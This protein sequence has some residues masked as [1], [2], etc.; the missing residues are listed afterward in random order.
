MGEDPSVSRPA[1]ALL[2]IPNELRAAWTV[3]LATRA[4]CVHVRLTDDERPFFD[5]FLAS[6]MDGATRILRI[7]APFEAAESYGF[8]VGNVIIPELAR[9]QFGRVP[10]FRCPA[11]AR[12]HTDIETLTA[13]VSSFA[14]AYS[15]TW[16]KTVA[17]A[18]EPVSVN[19]ERAW[20]RWLET[21]AATI[22]RAAPSVRLVLTD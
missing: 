4:P 8:V 1:D 9:T 13:I 20:Q 5:A 22:M 11:L 21:F 18:F 14:N 7:D 10:G 12:G 15:H 3:A 16:M 6:P 19:D 17:L 2:E